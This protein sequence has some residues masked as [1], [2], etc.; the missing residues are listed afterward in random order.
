M[1][2][3][4]QPVLKI[5]YP[6]AGIRTV[7]GHICIIIRFVLYLCE[8]GR[9]LGEGLSEEIKSRRKLRRLRQHHPFLS[10]SS[11]MLSSR[12]AKRDKRGTFESLSQVIAAGFDRCNEVSA[13]LDKDI[14]DGGSLIL[15]GNEKKNIKSSMKNLEC[16][17]ITKLRITILGAY[18][19]VKLG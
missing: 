12:E 1:I 14:C 5:S 6:A 3:C 13:H 2:V 7:Q 10:F 11:S 17:H 16:S 8:V 9:L 15:S 19:K 18:Q 4:L